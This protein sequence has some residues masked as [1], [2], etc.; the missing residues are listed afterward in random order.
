MTAPAD[1]INR[2]GPWMQLASGGAFFPLDPLPGDVHIED[3]AHALSRI[4]RFNGHVSVDHYSVAEHS[5]Y[6]SQECDVA[7]AIEGLL[8]DAAEAYVG[9]VIRPIKR[10][11]TEYGPIERR[12]EQAIAERFGLRFPWPASVKVADDVVL[13]AEQRD[14]MP[15]TPIPD[16]DRYNGAR[17]RRSI[18][19]MSSRVARESFLRRFAE[20]TKG[21]AR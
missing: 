14:L 3:I 21:R 7:D 5:V 17:M 9:D 10:A 2:T 4:C 15:P 13:R 8:H 6:V 12:V 18:I 16:F 20:L 1:T 19:G 11:L